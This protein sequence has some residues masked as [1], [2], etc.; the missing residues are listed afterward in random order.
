MCIHG[1]SLCCFWWNGVLLC[2]LAIH[3]N[4]N[5]YRTVCHPS[6]HKF[7]VCVDTP[8]LYR[9]EC[10]AGFAW[11]SKM[12][13]AKATNSR[14]EFQDVE[15]VGYA[16]L[17]GKTFPELT[18]FT[19]SM[20]VRTKHTNN[21][22]VYMSYKAEGKTRIMIESEKSTTKLFVGDESVRAPIDLDKN[23]KWHHMVF[24]WTNQEG[25]WSAHLDG[26]R[27]L[28][29][30]GLSSGIVIP[31]SG[32]FVLGQ[33][34]RMAKTL[35]FNTT[36]K[37]IGDLSHVNI[38][39]YAMNDSEIQSLTEDC[40][41]MECGDAVQWVDFRSGTRGSMKLRWPSGIFASGCDNEN[42]DLACD[43]HCS[44]TIG[45]QCHLNIASN[46]E[47]PR[48]PAGEMV[49]MPCPKRSHKENE[50]DP[51]RYG[52]RTC[53]FIPGAINGK[54]ETPYIAEC[55]SQSQLDLQNEINV[56]FN[57]ANYNM[58][59]V[60]TY[61]HKLDNYTKS[62]KTN[63]IDL[64]IDIACFAAIMDAQW[65]LVESQI[66][67]DT[68]KYNPMAQQTQMTPTVLP[69]LGLDDIED[70]AKIVKDIFNAIADTKNDVA[71]KQTIPK[72]KEAVALIKT[73]DT[74]T[75]ILS[76]SL[77]LHVKQGNLDHK[78]ASISLFA[79]NIALDVSVVM[80]S[81]YPG[82]T[83]P[84]DSFEDLPW[85]MDID[86]Y[87]SLPIELFSNLDTEEQH[88]YSAI[89]NIKYNTLGRYLP[90]HKDPI[91]VTHFRNKA[92]ENR[93]K[94]DNINT[95]V[96][97][98]KIHMPN[99]DEV[100]K[101]MTSPI[102][103]HLHYAETFNVSN[104]ECVSL[105]ILEDS[106]WKWDGSGCQVI[107]QSYMATQCQCSHPGIFAVT[108]DMYDVNWN[109]CNERI[110]EVTVAGYV[111]YILNVTFCVAS[112]ILFS[113]FKCVSDTVNVHRNLA[114][115]VIFA[116][117]AYIVGVTRRENAD[118]CKGFAILLHY[119]FTAEF[120]WLCNEAFN[121]YV[122][123]ANSI[124]VE[125]QQQRPMLR[126]YIIGWVFPGVLVGA[127]VGANWDNYFADDVC[128]VKMEQIWLFVGPVAGV[129]AITCFVLTF[130]GK[131]IVESSYSKDKLANKVVSNHCKGCWVQM[132]LIMIS[133]VFAF[134]SIKMIGI[135]L[136]VLYAFFVILQG[137]F[138]FVFM[139]ILNGEM[140]IALRDRRARLG[141][142]VTG[143]SFSSK[144]SVYRR[145]PTSPSTQRPRPDIPDINTPGSR[146]SS[147]SG[148]DEEGVFQKS[149]NHFEM[150]SRSAAA[151]EPNQPVVI[152]LSEEIITSV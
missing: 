44:H 5:H 64:S 96:M 61:A 123:V 142:G 149:T 128:W 132:T 14:L 136:Q 3:I 129:W 9:C 51:K 89:S 133:W 70:F 1:N 79:S 103:M 88:E 148:R 86:D 4:A 55:A 45:P 48:T 50:D 80:V 83:F 91:K 62:R 140:A 47:W 27:I 32:E 118:V 41:F 71:W 111:G 124:H 8:D 72:G 112:L 21:R 17:L 66:F 37:Y 92:L 2:L 116:E 125:T 42:Y 150:R 39:S 117:T 84:G 74:F 77:M 31:D 135:I 138:L 97:V 94:N 137:S 30:R 121:L 85:D 25:V 99:A 15:Q 120:C 19:A 40:T 65:R 60:L 102:L 139:C 53:S 26:Q 56:T 57:R 78:D 108:T 43:I 100:F 34:P 7:P 59:H 106:E 67:G 52:N 131:D 28:E 93:H 126:Y 38:W 10:G 35:E 11:N 101:N 146:N 18:A 90:N 16:L 58:S 81:G 152:E 145:T 13:V 147:F 134:V 122:E 24:T 151:A 141:L 22:A 144:Y 36:L 105:Q 115:S 143:T 109:C 54:W 95:A 33:A 68:H 69:Y 82:T 23:F 12:C 127:L 63:P 107:S 87:I 114:L 119:F 20:W 6:Y 104:P 110:F 130:T 73:M 75:D 98:S 46:I 49:S 76:E 29:G 113:Y